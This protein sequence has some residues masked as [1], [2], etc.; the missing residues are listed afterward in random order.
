M[1]TV[2]PTGSVSPV[3]P[4][5]RLTAVPALNG[6]VIQVVQPDGSTTA[7]VITPAA[8]I[9]A[10][11]TTQGGAALAAYIQHETATERPGPAPDAT[12]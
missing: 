12:R 1:A 3:T 6:S 4:V 10:A 8:A 7:Q 11:L 2:T 9:I 5:T